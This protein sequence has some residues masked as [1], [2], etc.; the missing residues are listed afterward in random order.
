[1]TKRKS[2]AGKSKRKQADDALC[3]MLAMAGIDLH[4]L[5]RFIESGETDDPK[6]LIAWSGPGA[7][8]LRDDLREIRSKADAAHRAGKLDLALDYGRWLQAE[9]RCL[10]PMENWRPAIVE[11]A[12]RLKR[13][14][15][16]QAVTDRQIINAT[17]ECDT[18]IAAAEKLGISER[19]L[20]SRLTK[21]NR[22]H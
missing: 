5:D 19:Q 17:R 6:W 12:K 10:L 9:V 3:L 16:R 11:K 7:E 8:D 14:A 15:G 4:M 20:R 13:D 18:Q 21:I 1:M 22:K 2:A